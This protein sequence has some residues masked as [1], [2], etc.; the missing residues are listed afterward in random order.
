V[1]ETP[2]DESPDLD[3]YHNWLYRTAADMLPGGFYDTDIDDLVQEGRIAMWKAYQTYDDCKGT[4]A[5]WL[6][7]AA[8]MRMRDVAWGHGRW[9]GHTGRRGW[10][11][12]YRHS[13]ASLLPL[14]ELLSNSEFSEER[15]RP[16]VAAS[17]VMTKANVEAWSRV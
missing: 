4:L 17:K 12:A 15:L 16:L 8:R 9:T 7:N 11:D 3:A 13:T 14:D 5:P 6:T 1:S 10:T 2:S